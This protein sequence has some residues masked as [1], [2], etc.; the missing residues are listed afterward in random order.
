LH[1]LRRLLAKVSLIDNYAGSYIFEDEADVAGHITEGD[2]SDIYD[3]N[4][5]LVDGKF[6]I[7]LARLNDADSRLARYFSD[8]A[9]HKFMLDP[10]DPADVRQMKA[11]ATK[12]HQQF[13]VRQN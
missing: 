6:E 5:P 3:P 1:L 11:N 10:C 12:K 4:T 7:E 8:T 9:I 2:W 13:A